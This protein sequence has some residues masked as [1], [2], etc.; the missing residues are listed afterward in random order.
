MS[1]TDS[2]IE[3]VS[4]EV[5]RDRLYGYLRR[6]GWIAVL[7]VVVLVGGAAWREY[8]NA[9]ARAAAEARGDAILAAVEAESPGARA[10]ALAAVPDAGPAEPVVALFEA[11]AAAEADDIPAAAAAYQT[12]EANADLPARYRHLA[13]LKRVILQAGELDPAARIAAMGPLSA[14]GA[15]YRVLAEEQIALAEIE[16][17]ETEAAITRLRALLQDTEATAGLRQRARQLIVSL[18]GDPDPA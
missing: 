10:A 6:Y 8:S 9:Q 13:T 7:I 12:I 2:F 1:E 16:T 3:E 5:R 18:G 15:P 4:E 11:A 14:P 17:G